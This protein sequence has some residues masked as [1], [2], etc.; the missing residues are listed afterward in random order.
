MRY[1]V[2]H[3]SFIAIAAGNDFNTGNPTEFP[4]AY[5][6]QVNGAVAVGA[7]GRSLRRAFYSSTG[8]YVELAAPGGDDS[9]GGVSGMI[10]QET[11][12]PA[13]SDPHHVIR[14]RFDRYQA[15]AY[16]GTSMAAPHAAGAAALLYAQGITNPAAIESALEQF[17][18]DL[19]VKGRDD[20]YGYGLIN[21]RAALRGL[22]LAK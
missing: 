14:P 10:V 5:A 8:S 13:D 3:G 4:A 17:A 9:D 12:V 21:P 1:A 16:E 2:A 15:I 7:V 6:S 18:T 19:G 11:L 20:E 22:G